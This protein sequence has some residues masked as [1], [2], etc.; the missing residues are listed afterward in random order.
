MVRKP[1]TD[2]FRPQS[3][4]HLEDETVPGLLIPR[5]EG[6]MTFASA[7]HVS[8]RLSSLVDEANSRVVIVECSAIP[9]FEYTALMSLI[10]A[11]ERLRD[12]G[13][14]LWRCAL[15]P[16][17]LKMVNASALGATLGTNRMFFNLRDAVHA[18]EHGENA[19]N[20]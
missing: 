5:T 18:F 12:R 17:A 20:T 15:N 6:R 19:T 16:E 1:G 11:E 9:D 4:Q 14:T 2:V 8:E 3:D 10:A 7:P 13:I